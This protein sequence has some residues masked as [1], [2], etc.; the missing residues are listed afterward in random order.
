M[1]QSPG[2]QPANSRLFIQKMS[3]SNDLL[4]LLIRDNNSFIVKRNGAT[5]SKEVNN[6][7]HCVHPWRAIAFSVDGKQNPHGN[8]RAFHACIYTAFHAFFVHS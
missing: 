1:E 4:W 7:F 2:T 3:T 6:P 8:A 5:F